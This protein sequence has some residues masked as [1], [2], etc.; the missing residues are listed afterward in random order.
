M[1][2]KKP[3][4]GTFSLEKAKKLWEKFPV[5]ARDCTFKHFYKELCTMTEPEQMK[6]DLHRI[7]MARQMENHNKVTIER[8]L[9][10]AN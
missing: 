1:N 9:Q 8:A 6:E 7:Q 4:P 2:K 3:A 10:N 5:E